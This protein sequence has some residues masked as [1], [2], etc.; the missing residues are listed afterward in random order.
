MKKILIADDDPVMLTL[1]GR[2]AESLGFTPIKV[3]NGKL[4][5]DVLLDNPDIAMLIT[6]IVMPDL[7]GRDLV[8]MLRAHGSF[9]DLPIIIISGIVSLKEIDD[10]LKLGVSR[11]LIKPIEVSILREYIVRLTS[12]RQRPA[13]PLPH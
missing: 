5:W 7:D 9:N 6:D 11:F 1:L 12:N 3:S 13:V 4:C 2:T 10:V 8:R